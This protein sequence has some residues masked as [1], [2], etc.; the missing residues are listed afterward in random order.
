MHDLVNNVLCTMVY[1]VVCN[2]V[3]DLFDGAVHDALHIVCATLSM[4]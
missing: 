2:S 1:N 4:N 3:C